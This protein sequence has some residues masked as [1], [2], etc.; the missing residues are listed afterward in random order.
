MVDI[1]V[2]GGLWKAVYSALE[3]K[4]CR[5]RSTQDL[6]DTLPSASDDGWDGVKLKYS[7]ACLELGGD[8]Q[9]AI[10]VS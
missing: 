2:A 10:I 1:S 7:R 3:N 9:N 5:K 6:G 8:G 4:A